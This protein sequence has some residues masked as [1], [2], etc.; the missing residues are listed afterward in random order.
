VRILRLAGHAEEDIVSILAWS[1]DKFGVAA[2]R[3]Y[4]ALLV[5]ALE[6]LR[7]NPEQ[8]G[9]IARPEFGAAIR[10]YHLRFSR[11]EART[12]EGVV[13]RPRHLLL[14]RAVGEWEIDIVRV[15]HDSMELEHHLS[16]PG[17]E[18]EPEESES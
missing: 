11:D 3:R 6:E 5:T 2:C 12:P 18:N 4:E 16:H 8:L 7:A 13:H 1:L 14:Y 17:K 15:L 9:S 10:T